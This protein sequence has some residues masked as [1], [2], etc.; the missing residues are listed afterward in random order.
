MS[1]DGVDA[2]KHHRN[3]IRHLRCELPAHEQRLRSELLAQRL[4]KH[5]WFA[6]SNRIAC[7]LP[8]HGEMGTL[9][10]I[11]AATL[12]HKQVFLPVLR[13]RPDLRLK[14]LPYRPGSK[15]IYNR[16][17]IPEPALGIRHAVSAQSLD[18][19]LIPLVAFDERGNR[20]GTGAGYYDRTFAYLPGRNH[21]RRPRL[22]G[23]AY[24]F[25]CIE[26]VAH[27]SWD[28]PLDGVITDTRSLIIR[29]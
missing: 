11:H 26:S 2:R 19:V 27:A 29:F 10:A 22:L 6:H 17:G 24:E 16:F 28:V 25:Q 21:W 9:P 15:L 7:Y 5:P 8:I 13:N 14:F 3:R 18:L 1:N 4:N 12:R 20:L 23:L